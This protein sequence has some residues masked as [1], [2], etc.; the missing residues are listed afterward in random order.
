MQFFDDSLISRYARQI[1]LA[2]LSGIWPLSWLRN[3]RWSITVKT[4]WCKS[5][6]Q[7]ASCFWLCQ[8]RFT[9]GNTVLGI[10]ETGLKRYCDLW[11]HD[12]STERKAEDWRSV[13]TDRGMFQSLAASVVQTL[14]LSNFMQRKKLT[15]KEGE[16]CSGD[17]AGAK[18]FI[19]LTSFTV[20]D[21]RKTF[22]MLS[23]YELCQYASWPITSNKIKSIDVS[24]P[25]PSKLEN[26][27]AT[28][29][30]LH[31]RKQK[32]VLGERIGRGSKK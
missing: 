10:L 8:N 5:C 14:M 13:L 20:F 16:F 31:N 29:V 23:S 28:K 3:L 32:W 11:K 4:I 30:R 6:P 22:K 15:W 21:Y 24:L 1:R 2:R 19:S 12:I 18:V 25:F 27:E 26:I 17:Q 7:N 9:H